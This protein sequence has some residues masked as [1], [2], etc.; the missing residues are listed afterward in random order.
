MSERKNDILEEQRRA[1]QQFLELKKMQQGELAPEP[2]PSE[3]ALEPK[4]FSEKVKNYWYHFKWHTIATIFMALI[5]TVLTVQCVNREKYDFKVVYFGYNAVLDVNLKSAEKYL[6]NF[7]TD[8]DGDGNVNVMIIN[9]SFEE[10]SNVNYRNTVLTKVQSMIAAGDDA[11]M[12]IVDSKAEKYLNDIFGENFFDKE[13]KALSENFYEKT[14]D[15]QFG[16]LP[17][18]LK[19]ANRKVSGTMLEKDKNAQS[20]LNEC[21]EVLKKIK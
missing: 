5:I 7:A 1:R 20:V 4:T 17:E 6:E 8:I 19:I 3:V 15:A 9:C 12:Y 10:N 14:K 16:S 18:G 21:K 13:P 2:K 11:I